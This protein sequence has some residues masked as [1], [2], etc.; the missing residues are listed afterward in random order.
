MN[1]LATRAAQVLK[2]ND[3]GEHTVPSPKLYPHQWAWDSA[4]A[5][6]GWAH[7]DRGRALAELRRLMGSAWPDGRVPHIYFDPDA[8]GYWPDPAFWGTT[9]SSS[10][11][12]PPVWGTAAWRLF[13]LGVD[14]EDL[15]PLVPAIEASHR[16]FRTARDPNGWGLV[17]VVHPWESGLDN[18]PVWDEPLSQIDPAEAPPFVRRDVDHVADPAERPTDDH[19]RRYA[20]IVKAIAAD[21][22]GPGPFAVYDPL[23]TACLARSEHDLARLC[24]ALSIETDAALRAARI[25]KALERLWDD[26]L[27]RYRYVDAHG[28]AL[29]A[30]VVGGYL[31]LILDDLPAERRA[32]LDAGLTARFDTPYPVPSTAPSDPAFDPRRYWRGP[33]WLNIDWLLAPY[34]SL[35]LKDRALELADRVG[36]REYYHPITGEGLGA[37]QFTWSAALV[38]DWLA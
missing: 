17:A 8:T 10:I 25:A 2:D 22:F 7:V 9:E 33:T 38:L 35:P 12:Q 13:E 28:G 18:C 24:G 36:F 20:V 3:R 30:E 37:D 15:R 34:V 14:G 32:R 11:T 27:G 26:A 16:F 23:M 29:D 5:A 1:D 6:I 31:P 21:D 4:F 19:Y